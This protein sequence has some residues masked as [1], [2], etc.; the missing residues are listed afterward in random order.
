MLKGLKE[1]IALTSAKIGNIKRE[2][3][4]IEKNQVEI[5]EPKSTTEMKNSLW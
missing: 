5:L 2:M 1:N 4:N 3:E